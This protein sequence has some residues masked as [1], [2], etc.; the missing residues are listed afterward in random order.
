NVDV[1]G[2]ILA[3]IR[4][5]AEH[6]PVVFPVHPRTRRRLCEFGLDT[7]LG[8]VILTDPLGY[9]DFLSL[10]SHARLI[11]T[12]SG[13]LQEESTALG[14]PV[15]TFARNPDRPSPG[16]TAPTRGSGGDTP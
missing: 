2:R 13:G 10:T 6:L 3:A 8:D 12:D 15:L 7:A 11:L 16:R 4:T 1:F 9:I 5:I 14:I